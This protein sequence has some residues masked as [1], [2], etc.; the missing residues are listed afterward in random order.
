MRGANEHGHKRWG[1]KQ[2]SW[3]TAVGRLV[4]FPMRAISS[5]SYLA[6]AGR[7]LSS[8]VPAER[9]RSAAIMAELLRDLRSGRRVLA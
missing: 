4:L 7:R 2:M 1:E 9:E 3:R 5:L 6:I 8:Q